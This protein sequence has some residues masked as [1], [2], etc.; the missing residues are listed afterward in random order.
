MKIIANII[1]VYNEPLMGVNVVVV[2][3]GSV[4]N[5]G[6]ASDFNGKIIIDN[7]LLTNNSVLQVSYVGFETRNI[8]IPQLA[9]ENFDI[10][11][12]ETGIQGQNIDVYG[13]RKNG[14]NLWWLLL[15]PVGYGIYKAT[16][17]QPKKV[18]M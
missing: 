16:A 14:F 4:T 7:P 6:D 10:M 3:N 13:T 8:T 17:K 9:D 1:D 5:V 18:T 11:L 12:Q 2:N 15:I